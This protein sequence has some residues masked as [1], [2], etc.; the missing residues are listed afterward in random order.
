MLVVFLALGGCGKRDAEK[1]PVDQESIEV[2]E[3]VR[4]EMTDTVPLRSDDPSVEQP[5][6]ESSRETVDPAVEDAMK[7][8]VEPDV[9]AIPDP[10]AD[11]YESKLRELGQAVASVDFSQL[12]ARAVLNDLW[13][14]ISTETREQ[15][16]I[17]DDEI[18]SQF[19]SHMESGDLESLVEAI[20]P[21]VESDE[22]VNSIIL[23][24]YL[25]LMSV[26]DRRPDFVL[27]KLGS[28]VDATTLDDELTLLAFLAASDDVA[29]RSDLTLEDIE[30][31]ARSPSLLSKKVAAAVFPSYSP[32][33]LEAESLGVE[34][35]RRELAEAHN[36]F[37]E[38]YGFAE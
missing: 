36:A 9:S 23:R 8:G 15:R 28:S 22:A 38:R 7:G 29:A 21:L 2:R 34:E 27:D 10:P 16:R 18:V 13:E 31:L 26:A 11:V 32:R 37:R 24:K 17:G 19:E 12:E 30:V 6:T 35:Y 3:D 25:L 1:A 5:K 33:G 14:D 4:D 20:G